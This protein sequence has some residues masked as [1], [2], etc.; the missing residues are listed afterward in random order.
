MKGSKVITKEFAMS[1]VGLKAEPLAKHNDDGN[2][3]DVI[4]H[5]SEISDEGLELF[6]LTEDDV[7]NVREGVVFP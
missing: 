6:G 5:F 2:E 3:F 1:L 7:Q 4:L